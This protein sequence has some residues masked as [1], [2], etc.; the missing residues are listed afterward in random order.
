MAMRHLFAD[1]HKFQLTTFGFFL[2][3]F[4]AGKITIVK[5]CC[6]AAGKGTGTPQDKAYMPGVQ[7]LAG[8]G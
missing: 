8:C 7:H 6:M 2:N 1:D 5:S 4:K 3:L